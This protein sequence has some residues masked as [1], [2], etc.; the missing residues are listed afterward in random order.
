MGSV[1]VR[2]ATTEAPYWKPDNFFKKSGYSSVVESINE[3]PRICGRKLSAAPNK[4]K[5]YAYLSYE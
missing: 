5:I 3:N 4:K 2:L 1:V